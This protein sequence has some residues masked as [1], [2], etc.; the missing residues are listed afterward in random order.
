LIDLIPLDGYERSGFV[1]P[2]QLPHYDPAAE[3]GPGAQASLPA[4]QYASS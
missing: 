3:I 2:V 1:F 4:I